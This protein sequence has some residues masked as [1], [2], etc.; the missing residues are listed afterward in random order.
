M[1][2]EPHLGLLAYYPLS[3][4]QYC[5]VEDLL[6]F[7]LGICKQQFVWKFGLLKDKARSMFN[8]PFKINPA[9]LDIFR[10]HAKNIKGKSFKNIFSKAH[11]FFKQC[12]H[13]L[14]LTQALSSYMSKIILDCPNCFGRVQIVLVRSKLFWSGPNH[15][16][17]VQIRLFWTNF[18][19]LDLFKMDQSKTIGA[20]PKIF[21]WSKIFGT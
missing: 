7:C 21:W 3:H 11:L 18:F 13:H 17:E 8:F 6:I 15:F 19:N 9:T 4:D 2:S 12:L 5:T 16:G 14:Q 10:P 20:R 1:L